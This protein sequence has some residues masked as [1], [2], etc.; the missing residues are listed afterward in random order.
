KGLVTSEP[1]K[2]SDT[3]GR[4]FDKRSGTRTIEKLRQMDRNSVIGLVPE[5]LKN[6]DTS[7]RKF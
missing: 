5:P 2:N 7:R 4:K 3:S 6:S 1:L